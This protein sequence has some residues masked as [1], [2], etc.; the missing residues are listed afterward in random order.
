MQRE[1]DED[2]Y[3]DSAESQVQVREEQGTVTRRV[4]CRVC[5]KAELALDTC[6]CCRA[7]TAGT[8]RDQAAA[9]LTVTEIDRTREVTIRLPRIV[10]S[11]E[12]P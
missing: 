11:T 1:S 3:A 4:S 9:G 2:L 10:S 8:G 12:R 7:A 5:R 6:S